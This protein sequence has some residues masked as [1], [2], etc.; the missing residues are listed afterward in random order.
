MIL[1]V[2]AEMVIVPYDQ[3]THADAPD[4]HIAD[5]LIGPQGGKIVCEGQNDHVVDTGLFQ[6]QQ[7]FRQGVEQF[8]ASVQDVARMGPQRYHDTFAAGSGSHLAQFV[9][10]SPVTVVYAVE[11]TDRHHGVRNGLQALRVPKYAH[12][13]TVR[14][15]LRCFP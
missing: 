15:C 12:G 13:V 11:R 4:Q 1:M 7:L 8:H 5:K 6:K 2:T 9:Q 14:C 10:Q 3:V